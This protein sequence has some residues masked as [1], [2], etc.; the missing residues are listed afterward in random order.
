VKRAAEEEEDEV[1]GKGK[2]SSALALCT[3]ARGSLK[4][5]SS[6]RNERLA[7]S[8]C[9]IYTHTTQHAASNPKKN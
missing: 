4:R 2:S 3:R 8:P 9:H 1:V 7:P 6:K 5:D